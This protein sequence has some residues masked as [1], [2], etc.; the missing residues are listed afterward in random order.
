M[1]RLTS[2]QGKLQDLQGGYDEV[3]AMSILFLGSLF[4]LSFIPLWISVLFIDI[5][6]ICENNMNLYTEYISLI[7]I[8]C[9]ILL[10]ITVVIVEFKSKIAKEAKMITAEFLLSYI[11]PLFTFDFT[12]WSQV[13][14]FLIFFCIL[15]FL[16]IRHMNFSVNIILELCDYRFYECELIN[17]DF[18]IRKKTI[19]CRGEISKYLCKNVYMKSLNNELKL[20]IKE[21]TM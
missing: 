19:I 12:I 4:F 16:C 20:L 13:V 7:L 18:V 21:K 8:I 3:V 9:G 15:G 6:S 2:R 10:S 11:L 14:L 5:Q 1:T 17:E